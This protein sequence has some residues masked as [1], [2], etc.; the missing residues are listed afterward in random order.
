MRRLFSRKWLLATILVLAA[1]GVMIRL[2]IWQLD[3]LDTRRAFNSRVLAQQN[4]PELVLED[5]ALDEPLQ[6]MEYR[7]VKVT[8]E[9]DHSQEI[10]LRN[11]YLNNQWGVHLI[12]PLR[13]AGSDRAV[14]VDRGWISAAD[15]ESGDWSKFNEPG[16]VIVQGVIRQSRSQADFGSRRDIVPAPGEAPL[17]AWNFVNVPAISQQVSLPLLPVYIQQAPTSAPIGT[18]VRTAPELDLTEG[19]HMGYAIQW[20]TFAAILGIGYLV[21]LRR[22]DSRKKTSPDESQTVDHHE[23]D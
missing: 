10:A 21:Y 19:P 3:R 17:R 23:T 2:G 11:Q 15:F 7:A 9:Y 5:E 18:P 14:L 6:E 20:F 8:G 4:Q 13:I 22:Q 1:M 16:K 12:T